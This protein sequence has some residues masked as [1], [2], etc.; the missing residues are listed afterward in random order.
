MLSTVSRAPGAGEAGERER[1]ASGERGDAAGG[2]GEARQGKIEKDADV[3]LEQEEQARK[4]RGKTSTRARGENRGERWSVE[5]G[6]FSIS[7]S[8]DGPD[9]DRRNN[10]NMDIHINGI[11]LYGGRDE[12]IQDGTL[13]L[14]FGTK[15]GLVGRN[16]CGKS[17]LLRAISER[18]I[19]L[20]EFLHIIH[21]EQEAHPD[22]R[23]AIQTVVDTDQERL[24]LLDLEKRM[25][26]EEL[27]QI[28]GIDLNEVYERLDEIEA[29]ARPTGPARARTNFRR[30]RL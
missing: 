1:G 3:K 26:D 8:K 14:V 27:D 18:V 5:F 2:D 20:P 7:H 10:S 11:Q 29:A 28:D 21:V 23:S 17:T 24:Y 6:G 13:K 15:Y 4:K 22:S 25:L 16:N 30:S 12:L 19:K 9:A